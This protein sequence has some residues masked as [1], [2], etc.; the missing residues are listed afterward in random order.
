MA[1]NWNSS[2]DYVAIGERLKAYRIGASLQAEDVAEQLG[3]SRAVIYRIERGILSKIGRWIDWLQVLETSLA[4]LL[5]VESEY[6]PR[7][8][9]CLEI[10]NAPVGKRERQN[11]SPLRTCSIAADVGQL[12]RR[13]QEK[14]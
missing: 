14:C 4:S 2:I 11:F 10:L 9:G 13:P 3:V 5:G 12:S 1:D 6:Y 8:W 7:R